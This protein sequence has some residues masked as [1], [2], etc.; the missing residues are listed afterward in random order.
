M[1][2]PSPPCRSRVRGR[3]ILSAVLGVTTPLGCGDD[4]APADAAPVDKPAPVED[5]DDDGEALRART[6]AQLSEAGFTLSRTLPTRAKRDGVAGKL[7]PLHE[8]GGR[9]MALK[10]V[11]AWSTVPEAQL[12]SDVIAGYVKRNGLKRYLNETET[13]IL[14]LSR[15]AANLGHAEDAQ[16]RL[17]TVWALCWILGYQDVPPIAGGRVSKERADALLGEFIVGYPGDLKGFLTGTSPRDVDE[18]AAVEDLFYCTHA[19]ARDAS[20]TKPESVPKT[21]DREIDGGAIHERRHA[22]TW[23]LSPGIAW[24]QTD[25]TT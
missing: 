16:W 1:P 13:E 11:I 24:D 14:A 12:P 6:L 8:I 10:A 9:A 20:G 23:A 3:L 2:L 7:R 17:E 4:A 22:L 15:G 21:F 5:K 19:A 18:V 25:L